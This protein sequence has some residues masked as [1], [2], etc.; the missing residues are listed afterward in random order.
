MSSTIC[1]LISRIFSGVS[2]DKVLSRIAAS[3]IAE[4]ILKL[5]TFSRWG[6]YHYCGDNALSWYD[7]AKLIAPN[8]VITPIPSTEYPT[9]AK[10]PPHSV[11]ACGKLEKLAGIRRPHWEKGLTDVLAALQTA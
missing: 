5:A 3:A 1:S 11:L 8:S 4:T 6:T 9:P 7:F 2:P 10:R